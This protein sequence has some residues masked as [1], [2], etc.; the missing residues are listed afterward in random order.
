MLDEHSSFFL[1]PG[2]AEF[3]S[4]KSFLFHLYASIHFLAL[5]LSLLESNKKA[6]VSFSISPLSLFVITTGLITFTQKQQTL[7]STAVRTFFLRREQF[8]KPFEIELSKE[9]ISVSP[10]G[11]SF[12]HNARE[13][14][15]C[16]KHLC[17]SFSN[18]V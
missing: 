15:F 5:F 16:L 2:H 18:N 7:V 11:A 6:F 12:L 1:S 14:F 10:E 9:H 8:E 3:P 17:F 4:K 13:S